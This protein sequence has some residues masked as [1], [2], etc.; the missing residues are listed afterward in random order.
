MK[1]LLLIG[2]L[3]FVP[4]VSFSMNPPGGDPWYITEIKIDN[5]SLPTGVSWNSKMVPARYNIKDAKKY[6]GKV[7]KVASIANK[8]SKPLIFIIEEPISP[9]DVVPPPIKL[10]S[11]VKVLN[12]IFSASTTK[13]IIKLQDNKMYY[14]VNLK[15]FRQGVNGVADNNP[16]HEWSW[17][18]DYLSSLPV[19]E[20]IIRA[21][22]FKAVGNFPTLITEVSESYMGYARP[23]KV[24]VPS[25][26][27]FR[28]K[29]FFDGK[30]IS[31]N[32]TISY[33]LTPNYTNPNW[34]WESTRT[35]GVNKLTTS[36]LAELCLLLVLKT[37]LVIAATMVVLIILIRRK[38]LR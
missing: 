20:N 10:P 11:E 36:E 33:S 28:L 30:E 19:S 32:G 16:Y 3:F 22:G 27:K 17:D 9:Y 5:K 7:N 37:V 34:T 13:T 31:I 29:S 18:N 15:K 24:V 26:Q 25:E 4:L 14:W 35:S 1:K 6:D 8:S 23:D 12:Y 21:L 38:N 2:V